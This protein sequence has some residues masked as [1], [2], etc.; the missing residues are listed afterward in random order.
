MLTRPTYCSELHPSLL[1]ASS[2]DA[3]ISKLIRV[4]GQQ[5][6][7]K[8]SPWQPKGESRQTGNA[9]LGN[10]TA[11]FER[12]RTRAERLMGCVRWAGHTL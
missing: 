6:H 1:S 11:T 12:L 4:G 8:A 2:N 5:K 3:R 9:N 10:E 7:G